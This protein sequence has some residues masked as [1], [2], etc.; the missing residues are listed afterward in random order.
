MRDE[1]RSIAGWINGFQGLV[2]DPVWLKCVELRERLYQLA[3][4]HLGCNDA[5]C[6]S[7]KNWLR[8]QRDT[9]EERLVE[10]EYGVLRCPECEEVRD[11]LT[12]CLNGHTSVVESAAL[13][14]A[15]AGAVD[16]ASSV[17][18]H[19]S[20][21][22]SPSL[23]LSSSSLRTLVEQLD[24]A[25]D[26]ALQF[27]DDN[28]GRWVV[29]DP[30]DGSSIGCV[31]GGPWSGPTASSGHLML[32]ASQHRSGLLSVL[33]TVVEAALK[34]AD[35][36]ALL[37]PVAV[38][39]THE[40]DSVAPFVFSPSQRDRIS[41]SATERLRT[42]AKN[43]TIAIIRKAVEER[44]AISEREALRCAA[45]KDEP[46]MHYHQGCQGMGR[47]ILEDLAELERRQ[48]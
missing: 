9:A 31:V 32:Y 36:A 29:A 41:A 13:L 47:C 21:S 18:A 26:K 37:S 45:A 43:E 15:E 22:L 3:Q 25:F 46:M 44:V 11:P 12:G 2:P 6:R 30:L 14:N 34:E 4:A 7:D 39:D 33:H 28:L 5:Q 42:M 16:P 10:A 20:S 23:V 40:D 27:R 48:G 35:L 24:R 8:A 17:G 38:E 19:N 1:L